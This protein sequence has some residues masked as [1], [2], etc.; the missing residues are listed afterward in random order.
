MTHIFGFERSQLLLLPE[1]VDDYVGVDNPVR[2]TEQFVDGLDLAATGF[3]RVTPKAT[4]RP[5]YAR[6]SKSETQETAPQIRAL[7]DAGCTK[8]FEEAASGGRWER[9]E[10]HK[11]LDQLRSGDTL[12]VWKL[13]RLSRSLKDLLTILERADAAGAKFRSLTE[14]ID[15]TGP[16][17][18]M[19]MQML[20]SFA[21][22]EREMIR[23]RTRAGLHEARSQ[24]R[25]P[26]RKPKITAAQQKE[27]VEAVSSG[28]KTAA[29][30][31]RLFKIHRGT[32]SRIVSQAR[33]GV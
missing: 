19:L 24:G 23:E 22:F 9:P 16:A 6:V 11:M 25:V 3:N 14:A 1:A 32:V 27:I 17:G 26:G 8:L 28:R 2:F 7:K 4:G 18:R 12:V 20:G 13:D 10:L 21:E 29:E 30:I 31:A 15:T 33:A 5:G